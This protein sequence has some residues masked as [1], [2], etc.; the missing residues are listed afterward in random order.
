MSLT[1]RNS[2]RNEQNKGEYIDPG[3]DNDYN[4]DMEVKDDEASLVEMI[5]TE[6]GLKIEIWDV[7]F[8]QALE[9]HPEVTIGRIRKSLKSL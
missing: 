9:G 7:D 8:Q 3:K 1:S 2:V 5:E 4:Y 6:Q